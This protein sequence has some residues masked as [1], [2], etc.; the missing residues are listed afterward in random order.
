MAATG[1]GEKDMTDMTDVE[2][3]RRPSGPRRRPVVID[4]HAHIAHEAVNA[5]TYGRSLIGQMRAAG[6]GSAI[7]AMPEAHWK[8]MTD[9]PTR[10]SDMD[11]MG[12]DMQV[13]SPNILHNCTYSLPAGE[14]DRLERLGNDHIAETI[15]KKPDRL[16]GLGSV[17]LQ[18]TALAIREMERATGVLGLKALWS[19][20]ASMRWSSAI[21]RCGRSGGGRNRSPCRSSS[22]PPAARTRGLRGTACCVCSPG[23]WRR[24]MRMLADL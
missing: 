8:R 9:L 23:R 19:P 6:E 5:A 14:A 1:S 18:D 2:S 15:A 13:I 22:I 17:P 20:R 24:P 10:L 3:T 11:A 16:V 7:H 12:V 4:F 21:R